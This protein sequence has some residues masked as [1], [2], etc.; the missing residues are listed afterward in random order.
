[1]FESKQFT[2][3]ALLLVVAY[4]AILSILTGGHYLYIDWTIIA[5]WLLPIALAAIVRQ[6]IALAIIC[7]SLNLAI[8]SLARIGT[9]A[10]WHK[11]SYERIFNVAEALFLGTFYPAAALFNYG[12]SP[13]LKND[14]VR[15]VLAASLLYAG[16]GVAFSYCFHPERPS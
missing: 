14:I 13:E 6:R 9:T 16:V 1:M 8:Y 4:A 11:P 2:I 5:V 7:A 10:T 15:V 12:D 3:R